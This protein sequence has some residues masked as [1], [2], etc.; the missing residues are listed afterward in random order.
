VKVIERTKNKISDH[1]VSPGRV[2][3]LLYPYCYFIVICLFSAYKLQRKHKLQ[4]R[5]G[6][7]PAWRGPVFIGPVNDFGLSAARV[8]PYDVV[9]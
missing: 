7:V 9:W 1:Y 4:N 2:Q 3:I 6:I 8:I 5:P